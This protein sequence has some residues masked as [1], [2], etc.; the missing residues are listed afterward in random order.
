MFTIEK[1][2]N[3]LTDTPLKAKKPTKKRALETEKTPK[4]KEQDD[5]EQEN[6]EDE[7]EAEEIIDDSEVN[8]ST[9]KKRSKPGVTKVSK[10]SLFQ[11]NIPEFA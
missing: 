10:Y 6:V 9:K 5:E 4:Q 11:S 8:E 3:K 7:K 2:T 1:L